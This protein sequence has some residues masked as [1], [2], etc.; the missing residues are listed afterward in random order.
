MMTKKMPKN[1][2]KFICEKCN[3]SCSKKSNYDKHLITRKHKIVKKSEKKMPK[4][5]EN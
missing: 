3:F 5:A 4:N 1:A 2:Q